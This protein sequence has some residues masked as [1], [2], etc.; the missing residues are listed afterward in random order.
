M[1]NT[2]TVPKELNCEL[3]VPLAYLSI[4]IPDNIRHT[5]L[6]EEKKRKGK[7]RKE[8]RKG[9]ISTFKNVL[10]FDSDYFVCHGEE[11]QGQ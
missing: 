3:L 9:R 2:L 11:E 10:T 8:K 6:Q 1:S 5:G 4:L 7:K